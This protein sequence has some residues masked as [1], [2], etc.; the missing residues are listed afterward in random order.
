[1]NLNKTV[2]LIA[3]VFAVIIIVLLAILIFVSPPRFASP[4]GSQGAASTTR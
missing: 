1:M 4:K 3:I 2:K